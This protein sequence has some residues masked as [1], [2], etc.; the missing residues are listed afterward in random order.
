MRAI[1]MSP[2]QRTFLAAR[3]Q[4]RIAQV[5]PR[6]RLPAL[7]HTIREAVQIIWLKSFVLGGVFNEFFLLRLDWSLSD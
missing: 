1:A 4:P 5:E 2:T 3:K 6:A 7:H